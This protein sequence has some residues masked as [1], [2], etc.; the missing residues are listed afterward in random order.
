MT[1]NTRHPHPIRTRCVRVID[2]SMTRARC[3]HPASMGNGPIVTGTVAKTAPVAESA[4]VTQS[5]SVTLRRG[6]DDE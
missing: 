1:A 2:A 3:K 4:T 6:I 5:L